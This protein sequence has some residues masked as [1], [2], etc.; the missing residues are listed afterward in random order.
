MASF[1][2]EKGQVNNYKLSEEDRSSIAIGEENVCSSIAEEING[3]FENKN[4]PCLLAIDGYPGSDWTSIISTLKGILGK[5]KIKLQEIGVHSFMKPESEIQELAKSCF[6]NDPDFGFIYDGKYENIFDLPKINQLVED[7]KEMKVNQNSREKEVVIC[8][9]NGAVVNQVLNPSD[10]ENLFDY[11]LYF[12]LIR[13]ELFN[14]S[15]DES[16]F[17]LGD[18]SGSSSVHEKLL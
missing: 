11:T 6:K 7:L 5:S 13:Q 4:A 2:T 10:S 16:I 8:Y 18:T 17:L 3:Y 15:E 12:D 9:G 1:Y 14:R